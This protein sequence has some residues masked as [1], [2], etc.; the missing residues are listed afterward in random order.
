MRRPYGVLEDHDGFLCKYSDFE[1]KG[2]R[3]EAAHLNR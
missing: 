3:L 1:Y 2:V